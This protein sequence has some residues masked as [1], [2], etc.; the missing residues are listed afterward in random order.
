MLDFHFSS[1]SRF[2]ANRRPSAVE[3]HNFHKLWYFLK[4]NYSNTYTAKDIW[5]HTIAILW[6]KSSLFKRT[7]QTLKALPRPWLSSQT[8]ARHQS[9]QM[10][11]YRSLYLKGLQSCRPSKLAVKKN[12][13]HFGFEAT[14]SAI[15][16][17]YRQ[18]RVR[19]PAGPNFEGL[20]FCSPLRYKV[21]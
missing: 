11:Y 1:S 4:K 17:T 16:Y 20:Q 19:Y 9:F 8:T 21:L 14:F 7:W 12:R 18:A 3:F 15:L 13:W 10:R 2:R 6:S 5:L